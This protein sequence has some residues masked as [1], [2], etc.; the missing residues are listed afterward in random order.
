MAHSHSE[1][2]VNY[3]KAFA[4]GIALNL[5]FVA[6]EAGYG[7]ASHSLA[8][9][10]DAGHNLSDVLSLALAWA[11]TVLALRRPTSRRTY[12][13]GRSS[14]LASLTNAALLLV[15]IGAIAWEAI[16][17]FS[18][19]AAVSGATVVTVASIGIV[20]NAA[21]ALMFASGRRKDINIK[22]AY[23]HMAADAGVSLGVV[24]AGFAIGATGWAWLDPATSLLI[25]LVVLFGTWDLLKESLDLALDAV[26]RSVDTE[27][28]RQ[29]LLSVEGVADV[30]DLHVWALS[31]TET[32]LTVHLVVPEHGVGDAW[33]AKIGSEL[34]AR[35]DIEHPTLQVERASTKVTCHLSPPETA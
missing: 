4:V 21:T 23:L 7:L 10:A 27:S 11:A 18:R 2:P 12:G 17:R 8:L 5:V 3:G 15:A 13:M 35:F 16:G 34:H 20:V 33:L 24:I 31:T 29:Y 1:G 22:G 14:I 9:V 26:P 25:V 19:P 32:A 6:V 28:V 30:H